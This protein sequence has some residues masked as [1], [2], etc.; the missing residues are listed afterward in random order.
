MSGN[1]NDGRRRLVVY[2]DQEACNWDECIYRAREA[3]GI[4]PETP[5]VA[6]THQIAARM[7]DTHRRHTHTSTRRRTCQE[8]AI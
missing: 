3:L 8:R 5:T 1:R 6:T 4:G 2:Y 7:A